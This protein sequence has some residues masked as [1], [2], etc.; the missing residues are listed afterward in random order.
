MRYKRWDIYYAYVKYKEIPGG[1]Q[2]PIIVY[3][4]NEMFVVS[5][6]VTSQAPRPGD[7]VIQDWAEAGLSK[8]SVAQLNEM[9]HIQKLDIKQRIGRLSDKDI[10]LLAYSA[11]LSNK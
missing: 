9:V 8:P 6:K 5:I 3:N 11:Q 4:D 2:R 10:Q 7:Y 1:K